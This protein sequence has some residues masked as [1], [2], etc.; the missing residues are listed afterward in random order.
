MID[1]T[2][3]QFLAATAAL[4]ATGAVSPLTAFARNAAATSKPREFE[5]GLVTYNVVKDWDLPTILRVCKEVG[6]AGVECRTTHRHGVEPSLSSVER[7][8]VKR[9]FDESG[10]VFWG[11]GS[12]CEFHSPDQAVVSKNIEECKRFVKLVADL[13]GTGVKVRPNDLPK[14]V[15]VEKTID[16][17][18]SALAE[19]GKAAQDAGVEIWVEVHGAKTQAPPVMKAIMEHCGHESVG[20]T[21]NSNPSEV[22]NGSIA[23]AF[24]ML[25][26]W[27]RSCH[28][29]EL[30]NDATGQYPYRELFTLL[31]QANYDRYT[32]IEIGKSYP[33]VAEGTQYLRDYKARWEM[34]ANA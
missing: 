17:I 22:Q 27:L 11:C 13:G 34:L 6:I 2:R 8:D 25:K 20:L 21:W 33:D 19:C 23:W 26:P 10:V 15:P 14:D 7:K 18:G 31:R 30:G 28:I 16:Q 9:Q 12:T 1:T 4:A 5:L 29:N 3:R 24:D 32:L